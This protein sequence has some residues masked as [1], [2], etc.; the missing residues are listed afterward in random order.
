MS[1]KSR[2]KKI[3]NDK[4][5]FIRITLQNRL[6]N[7]SAFNLD[8]KEGLYNA[9]NILEADLHYSAR[10]IIPLVDCLPAKLL[11]K[12][13]MPKGYLKTL[14]MLKSCLNADEISLTEQTKQN[15]DNLE[16]GNSEIALHEVPLF[17]TTQLIKWQDDGHTNQLNRL[18]IAIKHVAEHNNKSDYIKIDDILKD[19]RKIWQVANLPFPPGL[20][21]NSK[22]TRE[23]SYYDFYWPLLKKAIKKYAEIEGF[24][25]ESL[26]LSGK[27]LEQLHLIMFK[28]SLNKNNSEVLKT[29][30]GATS[31]ADT[32]ATKLMKPL[33]RVPSDDLDR[34]TD[35]FDVLNKA[36]H[37]NYDKKTFTKNA[38]TKYLEVSINLAHDTI[39][40]IFVGRLFIGCGFAGM[41]LMS[42]DPTVPEKARA[43]F[44]KLKDYE[45]LT[46]HKPLFLDTLLIS[47]YETGHWTSADHRAEQEHP[48]LEI[49]GNANAGDFIPK[50]Q[51]IERNKRTNTR[52]LFYNN[53]VNMALK[54]TP[55]PLF[56]V[57][58][59]TVE[60]K[61]NH[62]DDWSKEASSYNV[63]VKATIFSLK[64]SNTV[65]IYAQLMEFALGMG[66]GQNISFEDALEYER[67]R[68][69]HTTSTSHVPQ[70]TG[71]SLLAQHSTYN[72]RKGFTPIIHGNNFDLSDRERQTTAE[73]KT[74]RVVIIGGAGGAATAYRISVLGTDKSGYRLQND[75][76]E[77]LEDGKGISLNHHVKIFARG[78]VSYR[79]LA[80]QATESFEYAKAKSA[81]YEGYFLIGIRV[82]QDEIVLRFHKRV[83]AVAIDRQVALNIKEQGK[84]YETEIVEDNGEFYYLNLHEERCD[85]LISGMGQ[86]A[87][88]IRSLILNEI[89]EDELKIER[90]YD[91][92]FVCLATNCESVRFHGAMAGNISRKFT[93]DLADSLR[94]SNLP[95]NG[96]D[97]NIMPCVLGKLFS[98]FSARNNHPRRVSFNVNTCFLTRGD[99]R[100]QPT[101]FQQFLEAAGLNKNEADK[102][103]EFLLK[104][105][106][107]DMSGAGISRQ[108]LQQYLYDAKLSKRLKII[109]SC[110][111]T[112]TEILIQENNI[113]N[114]PCF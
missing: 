49:A 114:S 82:E 92:H 102:F 112:A 5:R 50:E 86:D 59:E 101:E 30:E 113:R 64:G 100:E 1:K 36:I 31:T 97:Q 24:S 62:Q 45:G 27:K 108:R 63:R 4:I 41:T 68:I 84:Q 71:K 109:S 73:S 110:S 105:R 47:E 34:I 72:S 39:P 44:Q 21:K 20:N 74:K 51:S 106:I 35:S 28:T 13:A 12:G 22:Y 56:G 52:H 40:S 65:Y 14:T 29:S 58:V 98:F 78:T 85:Q 99:L 2:Q 17:E 93:E 46:N 25:F 88:K 79:N 95:R 89:T 111:I 76:G 26:D 57:R 107:A 19:I 91:G 67:K 90:G 38:I 96:N 8:T 3:L 37:V 11:Y 55:P 7:L 66:E 6:K 48:L 70:T 33:K 54:D 60:K 10:V 77:F 61:A 9:I 69:N 104:Q 83:G 81:L 53:T 23:S 43:S 42:T 18:V 32:S 103:I 87:S 80:K 75:R 16:G 94:K 15:D